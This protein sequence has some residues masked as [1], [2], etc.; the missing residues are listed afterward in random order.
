VGGAGWDVG[1]PG[2]PGRRP[3]DRRTADGGGASPAAAADTPQGLCHE[4]RFAILRLS[5]KELK[6]KTAF[7][8]F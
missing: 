5:K 1:G 7:W 6:K 8:S 3:T 4:D 2:Q